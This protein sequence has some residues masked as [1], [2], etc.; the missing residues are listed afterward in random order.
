MV[1]YA[2][3]PVDRAMYEAFVMKNE[4]FGAVGNSR[5]VPT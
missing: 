4:S 2:G 3:E 5:T 1:W